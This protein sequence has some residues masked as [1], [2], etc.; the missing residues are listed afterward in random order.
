MKNIPLLTVVLCFTLLFGHPAAAQTPEA[1]VRQT[2]TDFFQAMADLDFPKMRS[3]CQPNFQ[4]LEHGEVWTL[5]ILEEKLKPNV[6]TGM[7]RTNAFEFITVTVKGK[8]AWVSYHNAARI[9]RAG[10]ERNVQWLESAV[11]QKTRQGWKITL[12]HSTVKPVK[13]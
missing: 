4:L 12:L 5:D 11:L 9:I 3:Y 10:Q 2:I 1:Q 7:Q 8:I 13:K 6:G